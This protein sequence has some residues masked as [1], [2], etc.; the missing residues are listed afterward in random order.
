MV[1][2][3]TLKLFLGDGVENAF[4]FTQNVFT[5]SIHKYELGFFPG[6]FWIF[7]NSETLLYVEENI[8]NKINVFIQELEIFQML[9]SERENIFL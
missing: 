7:F 1:H 8:A 9:G 2:V 6:V 5:F 4:A 3:K